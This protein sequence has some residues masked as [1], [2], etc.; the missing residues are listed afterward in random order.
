MAKPDDDARRKSAKIARVN[1]VGV[2]GPAPETPKQIITRKCPNQYNDC[3]ACGL[4]FVVRKGST[5][6]ICPD[7]RPRGKNGKR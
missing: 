2:A 7:C 3:R 5:L 1:A 4:P 6:G